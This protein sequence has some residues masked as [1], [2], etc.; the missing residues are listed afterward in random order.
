MKKIIIAL[1]ILLNSTSFATQNGSSDTF[2]QSII[3]ELLNLYENTNSRIDPPDEEC[4]D[5]NDDGRDGTDDR[6]GSNNGGGS[7]NQD[8]STRVEEEGT[9]GDCIILD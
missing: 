2:Y 8:G 3:N 9:G 4:E 1:L 5:Y 7:D 6:G